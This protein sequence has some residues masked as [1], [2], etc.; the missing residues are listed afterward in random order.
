[1]QLATERESE[2]RERRDRRWVYVHG[3]EIERCR[4]EEHWN[5]LYNKISPL[6]LRFL[7][8]QGQSGRMPTTDRD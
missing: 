3:A 5:E 1:M 8:T 6:G 4:G 2:G 7:F